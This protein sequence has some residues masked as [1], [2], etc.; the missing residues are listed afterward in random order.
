MSLNR[1]RLRHRAKA[2][3]RGARLAEALLAHPDRLIGL[4]LFLSTIVNVTTPA[5]VSVIAFR[6]GGDYLL[7]FSVLILA[8]VVFDLLRGGAEDL[9]RAAP[10]TARAARRLRVYGAPV[11]AV[12]L[13]VGDESA[14]ERR[15]APA[16]RV[17]RAGLELPE[18][19]G[20]AHRGRRGGRDDSQTPPANAGEH[21]R[22]GE[23]DGRG[24]HGA[25][26]RDR[27]HRRRRPVG[28]DH[29]AAAPEPAHA[30]ARVS[31]ATSTASSACCT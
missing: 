13:R 14:R 3:N 17:A 29:R 28:Q 23:R 21:A 6:L 9:R 2:G 18:Q 22:S 27:R 30:L 1:Y 5:L 10:G 31:R 25:A 8:A 15:A 24:H 20:A 16:R 7:A 12:S 11:G 26:R 19:R 4:I